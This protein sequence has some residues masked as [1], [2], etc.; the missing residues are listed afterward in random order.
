MMSKGVVRNPPP[1]PNIPDNSPT[2]PPSNT[3][4]SAFTDR[5]AMGR[6][7]S[8]AALLPRAR[9]RDQS[10]RERSCAAPGTL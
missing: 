8:T 10:A 6:Y 7:R 2:P 9:E 3:I 4:T 1:T 5:L